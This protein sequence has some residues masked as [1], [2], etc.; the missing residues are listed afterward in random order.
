MADNEIIDLDVD[1]EKEAGVNGSAPNVTRKPL[2][3]GCALLCPCCCHPDHRF[4]RP[5]KF[6]RY[7]CLACWC[8][9]VLLSPIVWVV[10]TFAVLKPIVCSMMHSELYPDDNF[11]NHACMTP[12][13]F[14]FTKSDRRCEEWMAN[15][16]ITDWR[17]DSSQWKEVF[18]KSTDNLRL[19]G[20]FLI[21]QNGAVTGMGPA[22]SAPTIIFVHGHGSFGAKSS[23]IL[24]AK[25]LQQQGFNVL[26]FNNQGLGRSQKP[27]SPYAVR[28]FGADEITNTEGAIKFITEDPEGVLPFRTPLHK[29]GL[30]V[31]SGANGMIHFFRKNM[32]GLVMHAS[33]YDWQRRFQRSASDIGMG[34]VPMMSTVLMQCASAHAQRGGIMEENYKNHLSRDVYNPKGRKILSTHNK[35]D[36]YN[37]YEDNAVPWR[38]GLKEIG[39]DV[40]VYSPDEEAEAGCSSHMTL[41]FGPHRRDHSVKMCSFWEDVFNVSASCSIALAFD[42]KLTR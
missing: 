41:Y 19:Q 35:A 33:I 16:N 31:E 40:Q 36:K 22:Q 34:W 29:V 10:L 37:L 30:H 32:P 21:G 11:V 15:I 17:V 25:M 28:A 14:T 1:L 13:N 26:V 38:K 4:R 7:G 6:T 27:P 9:V 2:R 3:R 39:F 8:W 42:T 18:F 23:V 12:S 20:F 5:C 24:P